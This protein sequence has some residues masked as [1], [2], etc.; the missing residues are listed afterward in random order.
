MKPLLAVVVLTMLSSVASAQTPPDTSHTTTT[1]TTAQ[2]TTQPAEGHTTVHRFGLGLH[3]LHNLGTIENTALINVHRD[4]FGILGSYQFNPLIFKAEI[5]GEYIFDYLNTNNDLFQPSLWLLAGGLVY[6]GAGIGI[7]YIDG[8]WQDRP[9]YGLRLGANLQ[10]TRFDV[11]VFTQYRFQSTRQLENV[12]DNLDAL[13]FGAQ[14][15]FG[16]GNR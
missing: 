12:V 4:N 9:F 10:I 8:D 15:R 6:G 3:Y 14:L 13:T 1:T 2:T 16:L 11:D 5:D 7:G